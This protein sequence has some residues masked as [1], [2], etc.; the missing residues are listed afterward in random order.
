[1]INDA[2]LK[3]KRLRI[4]NGG[5]YENTRFNKFCYEHGIKME[6]IPLGMSQHNGVVEPL[7]ET[8]KERGKAICA[9]LGLPKQFCTD[10]GKTSTYLVNKGPLAPFEHKIP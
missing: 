1:M 10:M 7:N 4:E 5:E 3:I 8:L 6:R 2:S 9:Q